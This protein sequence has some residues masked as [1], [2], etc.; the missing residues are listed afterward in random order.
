MKRYLVQSILFVLL[1]CFCACENRYNTPETSLLVGKWI[2]LG[3]SQSS[4][5][6]ITF[7]STQI[8]SSD[9]YIHL[10]YMVDN[11]IIYTWTKPFH[12]MGFSEHPYSLKGDTLH[13][14]DFMFTLCFDYADVI[15]IRKQ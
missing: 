11:G 6:V 10:Q 4:R 15:L 14:E 2:P 3:P 9:G 12:P 7:T 5:D 8:R 1:C 13:I